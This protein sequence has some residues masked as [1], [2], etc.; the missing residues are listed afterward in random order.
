MS[1]CYKCEAD[2][3]LRNQKILFSFIQC[4]TQRYKMV[5]LLYIKILHLTKEIP[6]NS[7][8]FNIY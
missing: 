1:K 6:N 8:K 5:T 4:T 2:K 7:N 3:T